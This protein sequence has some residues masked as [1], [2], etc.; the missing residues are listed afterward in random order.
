MSISMLVTM[1]PGGLVD[2]AVES[3]NTLVAVA[4]RLC[5]SLNDANKL[6]FTVRR[7]SYGGSVEPFLASASF[8]ALVGVAKRRAMTFELLCV[9]V[10]CAF[11]YV[12]HVGVLF[13]DE[14]S[15]VEPVKHESRISDLRAIRRVP[16]NTWL[17]I[18]RESELFHFPRVE[19]RLLRPMTL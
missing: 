3:F 18:S 8:A 10:E 6:R 13:R 19:A 4:A 15:G 7:E 12:E 9:T 11:H 16:R 14:G 5:A 2:D 17:V 1:E